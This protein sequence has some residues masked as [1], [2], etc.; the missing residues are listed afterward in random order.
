LPRRIEAA[1]GNAAGKVDIVPA[2]GPRVV[3]DEHAV[4][5][6]FFLAEHGGDLASRGVRLRLAVAAA[7]LF[8]TPGFLLIVAQ[9]RLF[10]YFPDTL[11]SS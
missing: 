2:T 10:A 3:I 11:R 7:R 9:T 4:L 1:A 6:V 8:P 5:E